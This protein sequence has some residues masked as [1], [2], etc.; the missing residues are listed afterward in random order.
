MTKANIPAPDNVV[1]IAPR[2]PRRAGLT[3]NDV[4]RRLKEMVI[5]FK[6]RPGERVNEGELAEQ[7]GVSR[8]PLREALHRL[9]AENMLTMVPNRGFYGRRIECQE[10]FD[11]YELRNGLE[12]T[13]INLALVRARDEDITS[14]RR[15]WTD[16][17]HNVQQ[18]PIQQLVAEDEHFHV[19]LARLSGNQ[20]LVK[21]LQAINARIHHFRWSDLEGKGDALG[22]DHLALVD[23]LLKRDGVMCRDLINGHISHRMEEI[24]QFIQSSVV[25]IYAPDAKA[26]FAL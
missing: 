6:I 22:D 21:S 5:V 7:L 20:E 24:V 2:E 8:T 16:V 10:V 25:R 3:V 18:M 26:L 1:S 15:L 19:S 11:L 12:L 14:L 23:A 4:H 13:A 17:M 9:V